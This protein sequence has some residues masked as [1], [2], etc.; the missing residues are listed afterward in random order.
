MLTSEY[1][2]LDGAKT[3]AF[4]TKQGQKMMVKATRGSDL[5]WKSYDVHG[6][7]WFESQISLY[8]FSAVKTTDEAVSEKIQSILKNAVRL[9]SEFLS[10]WKA[11][12]IETH[13]EFCRNWGLGSSSSL[14]HLVADWA[15]VNPFL[16]HFKVSQGSGYDIACAGADGPLVFALADDSLH[17]EEVDFNPSFTKNLYFVHLNEK[18]SS[19]DA[20]K[21]YFKHAKNKK[22]TVKALTEITDK[23]ISA[24]DFNEFCGLLRRH[25]EIVARE[26]KLKT[27]QSERFSEFQGLT[28]SL[29]AWGGD[30]VLA[31]SDKGQEKV[32]SYFNEKGFDT[33]VAFDDMICQ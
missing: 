1:Y 5:N 22:A 2:V 3:L 30:F 7:I 24:K 29:G 28:K 33:V 11:F 4:P 31:A 8:D 6:E 27:V 20:V 26:M 13:L 25:E 14:I 23:I 16:L 12:K 9:N 17:Y 10:N 18:Q 15:D 21:Y 19:D 32:H